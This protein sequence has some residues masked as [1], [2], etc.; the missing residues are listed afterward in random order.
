MPDELLGVDRREAGLREP[1]VDQ[2]PGRRRGRDEEAEE[3]NDQ[4]PILHH[5]RRALRETG[6]V[7]LSEKEMVSFSEK[8]ETGS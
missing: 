5:R 3:Q 8:W 7:C 2:D 1:R 4:L 6:R